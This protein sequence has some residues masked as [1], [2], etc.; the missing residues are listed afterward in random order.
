MK[1]IPLNERVIFALD[2]A[3]PGLAKEWVKRLDNNIRFFKVGLQLFL[4]GGWPVV[5]YI[6][7]RG[8]R[9]ML[10]LKFYDIPQTVHLAVEQLQ[11][12]NV[13]FATIHG[14]KSIIEAA[15]AG[16]TDMKLL[17]VTVLTSFDESDMEEMG[18]TGQVSD[19]VLARARKAKEA[20]CDGVVC[21]ALEAKSVRK[22]LGQD[23]LIVTPGIRPASGKESAKGDQKRVAAPGQAILNGANHVVIGRPISQSPDPLKTIELIQEDIA[24]AVE[25]L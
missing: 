22:G 11:N 9:V 10:D 2:F 4:A 13:D 21:S 15:V 18:F 5:D 14:S 19:L 25:S 6:I 23:F 17:A 1:N 20:G 12:R 3:E 8:H 24:G 16:K 7:D